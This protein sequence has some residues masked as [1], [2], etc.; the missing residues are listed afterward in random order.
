MKRT[1]VRY[2]TKPEKTDENARFIEKVFEELR[3][4]APDNVRYLALRLADGTF[5]H[6]SMSD[7]ADGVSPVTKLDAFRTFRSGVEARTVEPPQQ[8]EVTI[9]GNYRMLDE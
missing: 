8:T 9:V 6:F 3:A 1:V 4:K 7:T 5:I 2:K